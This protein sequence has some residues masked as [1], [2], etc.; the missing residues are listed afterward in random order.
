[1]EGLEVRNKIPHCL[2]LL[3][4]LIPATSIVKSEYERIFHKGQLIFFG[5][6]LLTRQTYQVVWQMAASSAVIQMLCT[7]LK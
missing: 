1:M 6:L 7:L 5:S 4:S 2:V 3:A